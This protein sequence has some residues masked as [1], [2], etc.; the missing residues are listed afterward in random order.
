VAAR[1]KAQEEAAA[2]VNAEALA[3]QKAD[4]EAKQRA[5]EDAK[6]TAALDSERAEAAEMALGLSANDRSRLQHALTSLGFDTRGA[7]GTF[8]PRSRDMIAGWQKAHS[9]PSTGFLTRP[10]IDSLLK[11]A[12]AASSR[13]KIEPNKPEIAEK[14]GSNCYDSTEIGVVRIRMLQQE[15]VVGTLQCQLPGGGRVFDGEYTKFLS[16]FAGEL[17]TSGQLL[18]TLARRKGFNLDVLVTEIA[19]RT[20][21]RMTTESCARIK[22]TFDF[23]LSPGTTSLMQVQP[24]FDLG[25]EMNI[26]ACSR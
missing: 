5:E 1:A 13:T 20:A 21:R 9:Q 19:N 22:S 17:G 16:K 12:S 23:A 24:P 8:G 10:Q 6:R 11:E 2:R 26:T 14:R 4:A 18:Q 25:P 7:D 3:K 15:L